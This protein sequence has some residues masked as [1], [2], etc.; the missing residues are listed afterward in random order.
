MDT[1]WTVG[2][3][4]QPTSTEQL[5]IFPANVAHDNTSL[6]VFIQRLHKAM[7]TTMVYGQKRP[8]RG[9][10]AAPGG[11]LPGVLQPDERQAVAYITLLLKDNA[12]LWWEA[13]LVA[14]GYR[15]PDNM[16]ELKLLL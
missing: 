12:R 8:R 15:R 3:T 9:G 4:R 11:R 2:T 16:A 7:R 1:S 6:S 13:E 5:T 14:R 10:L